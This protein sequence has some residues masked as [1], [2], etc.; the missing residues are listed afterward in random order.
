MNPERRHIPEWAARERQ[1]DLA[2][3]R[4]NL[5]VFTPAAEEAF[6]QYGRGALVVDTTVQPVPGGGHPFGYFTREQIE[7]YDDE[8]IKRLVREYNPPDEMVVVM[9]KEEGKTSSYRIQELRPGS[10]PIPRRR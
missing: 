2:W 1:S 3:I 6:A 9:L 7:A 4:D 5:H 8:D 10:R